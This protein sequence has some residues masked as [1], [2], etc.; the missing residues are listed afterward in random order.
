MRTARIDLNKNLSVSILFK[1]TRRTVL[2][3]FLFT[4]SLIFLYFI[5]N[6]Q[7]FLDSTQIIVIKSMAISASAL[8]VLSAAAL[9]ES[10]IY[11]LI[12]KSRWLYYAVHCILLFGAGCFGAFILVASSSLIIIVQGI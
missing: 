10:V 2:F 4:V 8:A 11:M 12:K 5:G 1:L 3:L 9:I 7:Q 6:F